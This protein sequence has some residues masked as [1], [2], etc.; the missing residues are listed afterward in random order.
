MSAR[1]ALQQ[2]HHVTPLTTSYTNLCTNVSI[3][4]YV[5]WG[6]YD[7]ALLI[8]CRDSWQK[9]TEVEVQ[10][11]QDGNITAIRRTKKCGTVLHTSI[12]NAFTWLD[13][14]LVAVRCLG[15]LCQYHSHSGTSPYHLR[16][17]QRRCL[18]TQNLSKVNA[19]ICIAHHVTN[20]SLMR[21][22]FP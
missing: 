12:A 19:A 5:K 14:Q 7:L 15:K 18:T 10:C 21:Y 22:R 6:V 9:L 3:C 17:M 16:N 2:F 11:G 13:K 4:V 20:T 8:F 1:R